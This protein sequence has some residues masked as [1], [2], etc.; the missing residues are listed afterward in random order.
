MSGRYEKP[1]EVIEGPLMDGMNVVGD[2]FGSGKMFLPQ[3]C[4]PAL[5]PHGL[6]VNHH[7]HHK[8]CEAITIH[9]AQ[10]VSQASLTPQGPAYKTNHLWGQMHWRYW[11]ILLEKN[12]HSL[13]AMWLSNDL[14][15]L[16]LTDC[17][18]QCVL[19]AVYCLDGPTYI[20]IGSLSAAHDQSQH[21]FPTL[22]CVTT[23]SHVLSRHH[24]MEAGRSFCCGAI[25]SCK[26]NLAVC[27]VISSGSPAQQ[28]CLALGCR[29]KRLP[30]W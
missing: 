19:V 8:F 13:T 5:T 12:N 16:F 28:P 9:T 15:D 21:C 24:C 11:E 20:V 17:H 25:K 23:W 26:T 27:H 4:Q 22:S 18:T 1:L 7:S 30:L 29:L 10:A 2:L 6:S 14:D 3:V